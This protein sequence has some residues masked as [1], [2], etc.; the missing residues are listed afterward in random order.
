MKAKPIISEKLLEEANRL[1][2]LDIAEYKDRYKGTA[3]EGY[4]VRWYDG[5]ITVFQ[6]E[7]T[8][9]ISEDNPYCG[10]S[11]Q[12]GCKLFLP[13]D[14]LPFVTYENSPKRVKITIAPME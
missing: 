4:A 5:E 12:D 10:W 3:I 8:R 14:A 6:K 2:E 9:L 11:S 7:P 1:R 13:D